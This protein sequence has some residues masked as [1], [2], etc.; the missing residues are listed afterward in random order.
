M[1]HTRN[2]Q[3]GKLQ[4][5]KLWKKLHE[6]PYQRYGSKRARQN[7]QMAPEYNNVS[8]G[9]GDNQVFIDIYRDSVYW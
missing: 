4:G 5:Y 7:I 9:N 2:R 1:R 8:Y 6:F 3:L